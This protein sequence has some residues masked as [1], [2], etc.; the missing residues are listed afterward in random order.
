MPMTLQECVSAAGKARWAGI[1]KAERRRFG[2]RAA[3]MRW[4]RI[5][6]GKSKKPKKN[7]AK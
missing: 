3:K 4:D 5:R 6:A 7:G 1:S 2:K